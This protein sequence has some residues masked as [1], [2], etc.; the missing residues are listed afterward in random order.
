MNSIQ[1]CFIRRAKLCTHIFVERNI[2]LKQ[3]YN[4]KLISN[5]RTNMQSVRKLDDCTL[6]LE[7]VKFERHR[8]TRANDILVPSVLDCIFEKNL[9][10]TCPHTPLCTNQYSTR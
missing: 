5:L 1:S 8:A 3:I 6:F 9:N 2:N 4:G 10:N 7:M